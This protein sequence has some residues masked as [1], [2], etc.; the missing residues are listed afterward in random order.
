[1]SVSRLL[2]MLILFVVMMMIVAAAISAVTAIG[3]LFIE[4]FVVFA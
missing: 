3:E 1:M 4:F 2:L